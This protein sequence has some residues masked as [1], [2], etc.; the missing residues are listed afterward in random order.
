M[1]V[2]AIGYHGAIREKRLTYSGNKGIQLVLTNGK[3]LLL[4][5]QKSDNAQQVINNYVE[6]DA[7][8]IS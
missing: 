4:G 6:K 2:G 1:V 5:T 7:T 3:K 8:R